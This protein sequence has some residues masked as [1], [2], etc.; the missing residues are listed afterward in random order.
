MSQALTLVGG[1]NVI[2]TAKFVSM[3]D[4]YFDTLN[5]SNFTSG[6]QK[7]KPFQNPFRSPDDFRLVVSLYMKVKILMTLKY[8][9]QIICMQWLKEEFLPYLDDWEK[10]VR[11][12]EGFTD[13]QRETGAPQRSNHLGPTNDW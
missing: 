12:R 3:M 9:A 8:C 4:K 6:K 13:A 7:R 2:E 10:S 1:E 5:V 11:K